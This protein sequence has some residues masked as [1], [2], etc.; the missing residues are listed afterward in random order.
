VQ[1]ALG[2]LASLDAGLAARRARQRLRS[3]G[4]H[5][6][7]RG[8]YRHVR[9]DALG[10]TARERKVLELLAERL[11]NREIAERLH[12]SERTVEHHVASLLRKLGAADRQE[13]VRKLGTEPEKTG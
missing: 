6:V 13:A 7:A 3:L 12:R 9:E 10:L 11:S 5:S 1:L 2:L 8:P 4:V